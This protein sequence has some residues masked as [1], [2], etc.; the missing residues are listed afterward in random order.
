MHLRR[1]AFHRN[2]IPRLPRCGNGHGNRIV[3]RGA[4]MGHGNTVSSP[5]CGH[6]TLGSTCK[7]FGQQLYQKRHVQGLRPAARARNYHPPPHAIRVG[8][9]TKKSGAV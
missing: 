2:P 4:N 5:R 3:V 6:H 9:S 7:D 1:D 8:V